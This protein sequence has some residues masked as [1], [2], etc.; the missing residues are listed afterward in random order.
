MFICKY[1]QGGYLVEDKIIIKYIKNKKE[2]G[3]KILIDTY[4]DYINT[5]VRNNLSSL[6]NYQEECINDIFLAIWTNIKSFDNNKNTFKNWI[7]VV[8]KYKTIDYKRKYLKDIYLED[9][10]EN[11]KVIDKNLLSIEV[12]EEVNSL[13]E[14]LNT[15]D[16][17]IF[18]KRYLEDLDIETIAKQLN[19]Q[20]ST[21]YTRISRCKKKLRSLV[22]KY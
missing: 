20:T 2:E 1:L 13:L 6:P 11:I 19:T 15:R 9:I 3:L 10:D 8:A 22:S 21:I 5:I 16:K 4:G 18:T 17:E 14:N 12:K 7:G